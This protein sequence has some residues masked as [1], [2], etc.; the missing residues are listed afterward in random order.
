MLLGNFWTI[1]ILT[2][3]FKSNS[4]GLLTFVFSFNG[5]KGL[6]FPL[7]EYIL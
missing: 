7:H 4:K 5:I 2:Y 3:A 1:I 6:V